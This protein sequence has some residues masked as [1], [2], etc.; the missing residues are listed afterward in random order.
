MKL[1]LTRCHGGR[2]L[3]TRKLPVLAKIEGTNDLDAFE[4]PGEPISVKHLCEPGVIA[5]LGAALP[6]LT[7][8]KIDLIAHRV[9]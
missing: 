3:L 9:L 5:L 7:P 2:Y 6:P 8:T 1:W 4:Q